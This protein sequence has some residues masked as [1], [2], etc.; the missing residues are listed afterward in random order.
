MKLHQKLFWLLVF[1]LPTQLGYHFW[2]DWAYVLGL[3][4]DYLSPTLYLTDLLVLAILILWLKNERPR[5]KPAFFSLAVLVFLLANSFLA[6][7]SGAAEY[8]L[9]KLVE[10]GLLGFYVAKNR[11]SLPLVLQ[12]LSGAV[13]YSSLIALGQFFKQASLGSLFWWLGERT[14]SLATPGIA[15]AVIK[16]RL[17]LRAYATFSHPNV[18]A[19]FVLV[20]LI[21][22]TGSR[23]PHRWLKNLALILGGFVLVISFSRSTWF[24]ALLVFAW[25]IYCRLAKS[26]ARAGLFLFTLVAGAAL[27]YFSQSLSG[28]EAVKQRFQLIKTAALMIK[29]HPLAGVGLNNFVVRL[30]DFWQTPQAVRF[31]QPVHNLFLLAAAET[32]LVGLV[33]F[34]WFLY[35]TYKK[36]LIMNSELL[37]VLSSILLLGFFDH[38]WFTLQQAQLLFAI[39]LGLG[40][41]KK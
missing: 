28:P 1:F 36:L 14:F 7:N 29:A 26:K 39:I 4:V 35:L 16:G 38:Y 19:G 2:P 8:K 20:S 27:F 15:K 22:I 31:L 23:G 12:A 32:G 10:F 41:A 6:T 5:L 40:W 9:V 11:R 21:L 3:R 24:A 30:P 13:I 37:I 18:L 33:L 17:L 25:R 34:F